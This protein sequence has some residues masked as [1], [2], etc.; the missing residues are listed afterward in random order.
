MK[1]HL[2]KSPRP[3]KKFRVTLDNGRHVD[4][5]ATGYSDY[6][7]HKDPERMRRYVMRHASRED[8]KRSGIDTPGFWSRWILWSKPS[9]ANAIKFTKQKFH[10]TISIDRS[11]VA[12]L[13]RSTVKGSST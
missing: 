4:F 6:T 2:Q 3:N 1:V 5:G 9:L 7:K 11:V 10:L 8:W 13:T 12:I